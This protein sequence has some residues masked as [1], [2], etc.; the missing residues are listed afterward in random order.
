MFANGGGN[1]ASLCSIV[2]FTGLA[3]Y[4][5]KMCAVWW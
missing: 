4:R 2:K 5:G 3:S 1:M